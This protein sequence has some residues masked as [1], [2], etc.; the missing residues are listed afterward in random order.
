ME[1]LHVI[2][3]KELAL[4]MGVHVNTAK[5]FIKDIKEEYDIKVVLLC[6]VNSY[7]KVSAKKA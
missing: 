5:R 2:T 7:F 4:S 1:S 3:S 6:H